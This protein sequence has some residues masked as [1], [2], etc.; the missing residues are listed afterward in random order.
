VEGELIPTCLHELVRLTEPSGRPEHLKNFILMSLG[1]TKIPRYI[2]QAKINTNGT[3]PANMMMTHAPTY[4]PAAGSGGV[5]VRSG[6]TRTSTD[7]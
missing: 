2:W 6:L 3:K 4:G 5:S 7:K 1:Q